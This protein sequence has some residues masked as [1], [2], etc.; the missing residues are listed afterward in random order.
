[1]KSWLTWRLSKANSLNRIGDGLDILVT[2]A[3]DYSPASLHG[4]SVGPGSDVEIVGCPLLY[5]ITT[6]SPGQL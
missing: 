5:I 2:G 4:F 3:A 1:M 6:S